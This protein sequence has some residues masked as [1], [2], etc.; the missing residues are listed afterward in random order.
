MAIVSR[1]GRSLATRSVP[2]G[3]LPSESGGVNLLEMLWPFGLSDS[4]EL[5]DPDLVLR[6]SALWR[7]VSIIANTCAMMPLHTFARQADGGRKPVRLPSEEFIWGRPNPEVNAF[8]F[9]ST[10]FMH[11]VMN[12]N[13]FLAVHTRAD[14][15]KELWPQEPR[16][17]QVGRDP[18]TRRKVYLVDGTHPHIDYIAGGDFVH[19]Q[20]L[21]SNGLTGQS[22][23]KLAA[24][25]MGISLAANKWAAKFFANMSAPGGYLTTEQDLTPA[26]AEQ[27]STLWEKSHKGT[28]NSHRLGV[29]G[30]GTKW[31]S[32]TLNPEDAMLLSTMSQGY[33][34]VSNWTGVPAFM[35]GAVDKQT[36]WGTGVAK[37]FQGLRTYTLDPYLVNAEQTITDEL[38]RPTNH[39]AKFNR[40]ALLRMD[41]SEQAQVFERL[42]RMGVLSQNEIREF[43]DLEAIDGPAADQ[44]WMNSTMKTTEQ[45]AAAKEPAA[46]ALPAPA[47]ET[48]APA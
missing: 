26:Q 23:V 39:Y 9:W 17:V 29:L 36:S 32:T 40:G 16:R 25:S 33:I 31:M 24:T 18:N 11:L 12:G 19:L 38:L 44:Y 30:K 4:G 7:A 1:I 48:P 2:Q 37:Q 14:G 8:T 22:I 45:L 20:G 41:P 28:S 3:M 46:P 13:A 15:S 43:L 6:L 42:Q 10:V 34:E 35:V 21:G 47:E 27:L 5:I